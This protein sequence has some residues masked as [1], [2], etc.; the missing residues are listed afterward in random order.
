[1]SHRSPTVVAVDVGG[2]FTD[3]VVLRDGTIQVHKRAST[4]SNPARAVLEGLRELVRPGEEFVLAHGSTVATNALL[5]RRGARTA[6]VTNRGFEDLV[7]IG[8]QNRPQLYALVGERPPPLV[9]FEDRIGISGRILNDGSEESPLVAEELAALAPRLEGA[10]SVAVGLL[11]SYANPAH[12]DAVAE[13]LAGLSVPITRS[14]RLLPEYREYER[15][16]TALVNA[17]VAPLVHK[18]LDALGRE[19]GAARV[20]IMASG[21]GAL[22]VERAAREPVH[23]ILS[24]PAGG[25]VAAVE[26]ARRAGF[27]RVL[28]FDMG[29]TSTDVSLCPGRPIHTKEY[30]IAGSAVAIPVLD[31]HTVGAGGGSIARRDPGGALK[32][33]PESA[34][35]VPGPI[36]YGLGG[37]EVTVTDA[38]V[39]LG[40]IPADLFLGGRQTLD[41]AAIESPLSALAASLGQSAERAAQGVLEVA[42][43][44]MEGALRL[45]SVERGHDPADLVLV[46]FGGAAPLHAAELAGR[47]GVPQVLVPPDPG[48]LSAR[49]ILVADV[50]KHA[51]RSVLRRGP[52]AQL[53]A[54]EPT[55][56]ELEQLARAELAAEGFTG[57]AVTLERAI[58]GR[59]GGQSYELEVAASPAW[60]DTFH[61]AHLQRFGFKRD[62]AVVEAVTLRVTARARVARPQPA[63][64]T[65]AQ[66]PPQPQRAT[67][68]YVSGTWQDVPLYQ[69]DALQAGHRVEGP[70]V[71]A[72]YSATTWVPPEWFLEVSESGDLLVNRG[73]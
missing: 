44:R 16:S 24:G 71:I 20:R 69:R 9:A 17:Y 64:L 59:Y 42:N 27:Q 46:A 5:E 18:Y 65:R 4:P 28:S 47:M 52:D 63:R 8:R 34:G 30:E 22:S 41:R 66:A 53:A 23:T 11:H 26:A 13:A 19:S 48:T 14:G 37:Q 7:E 39:W 36:C 43:T 60:Q 45:I 51:S 57:A 2:T 61:G 58:D 38:H 31:I 12:E 3:F 67:R 73:S 6:W 68:V 56:A 40:R 35:A 50:R 49:G 32:V 29:G 62:D 33:G 10:E 72:E 15:F 54:L 21:G 25:V 1:M 70:A 55:F